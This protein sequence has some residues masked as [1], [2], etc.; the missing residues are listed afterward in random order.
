MARLCAACG[1]HPAVFIRRV[2]RPGRKALVVVRADREHTLCPR[3]HRSA[4]D[5]QQATE[6]RGQA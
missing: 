5:R 2:R 3:C 1:K 6:L 4:W